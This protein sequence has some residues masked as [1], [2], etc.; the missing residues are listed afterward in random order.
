MSACVVVAFLQKF[1]KHLALIACLESSLS[2]LP[3]ERDRLPASAPP[4][5]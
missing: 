5:H 4:E 3:R 1:A 2:A